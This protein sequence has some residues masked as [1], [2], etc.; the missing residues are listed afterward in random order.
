[1]SEQ[2]QIEKLNANVTGAVTQVQEALAKLVEG[3]AL[4]QEHNSDQY[5]HDL[6]NPNS[7]MR[8]MLTAEVSAVLGEIDTSA[9]LG[10]IQSILSDSVNS[11]SDQTVATS[12][13]VKTVYD[14]ASTANDTANKAVPKTG[15]RGELA[16]FETA[17]SLTGS[18]AINVGSPDCMKLSTSGAVSLA[19]TP[20]AADVCALKVI[21]LTAAEA[22]TVTFSGAVWANNGQAP[23]WGDAGK[24]LVLTAHFIAGA[25]I[26]N[27]C[28]NNQ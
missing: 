21:C 28:D 9:V 8:Q 15:S 26:L 27:V 6:Q 5:A 10:S 11:A 4:L 25:V 2:S 14:L 22:T 24:R 23:A 3:M 16:G 7:P 17:A 1:M 12:K 18:Q 20:G 19:F 13:A